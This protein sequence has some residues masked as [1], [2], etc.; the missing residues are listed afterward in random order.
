[1]AQADD[2]SITSHPLLASNIVRFPTAAAA[3]R[4]QNLPAVDLRTIAE[5]DSH[6]MFAVSISR[7]VLRAHMPLI[8]SLMNAATGL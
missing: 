1:M 6:V 2:T 5:S 3:Q 4:F 8:A 7:E